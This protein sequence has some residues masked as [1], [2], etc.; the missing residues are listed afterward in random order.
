MLKLGALHLSLCLSGL[1]HAAL[2]AALVW[3]GLFAPEAPPS[4]SGSVLTFT[5][6]AQADM[7]ERVPKKEEALIQMPAAPGRSSLE[8]PEV[9]PSANKVSPSLPA[10]FPASATADEEP[11][12]PHPPSP[13]RQLP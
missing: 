12:W 10:P 7:P 9:T 4:K 2:F 5:L 11:S 6:I 13:Q 8:Q 3:T 1:A